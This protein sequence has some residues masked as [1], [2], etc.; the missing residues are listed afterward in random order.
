MCFSSDKGMELYLVKTQVTAL[1]G[2]NFEVDSRVNEGTTF[3]VYFKRR[4]FGA[5]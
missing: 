1:G 2:R 5:T 3:R 4:Q